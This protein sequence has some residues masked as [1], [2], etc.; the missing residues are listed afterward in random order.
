MRENGRGEGEPEE[1]APS[2]GED[3]PAVYER[4]IK[5][6]RY[7]ERGILRGGIVGTIG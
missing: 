5:S 4:G 1:G 3:A 6:D 7:G 2:E